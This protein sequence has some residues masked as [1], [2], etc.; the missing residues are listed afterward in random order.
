VA[1]LQNKPVDIVA[2]TTTKNARTLFV[3]D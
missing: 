3:I 1:H 2:K